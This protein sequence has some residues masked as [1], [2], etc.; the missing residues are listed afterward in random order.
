MGGHGDDADVPV[1]VAARVVIGADGHQARVLAARAAVGL[2]GHLIEAGDHRELLA[3]LL[4]GRRKE[5]RKKERKEERKK[6]T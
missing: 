1:V 3:Q 6:S 5:R 4:E 2:Q